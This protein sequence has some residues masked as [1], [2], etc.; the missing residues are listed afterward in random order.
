MTKLQQKSDELEARY[1]ETQQSAQ[2]RVNLQ[3][4]NNQMQHLD[5]HNA[6]DLNFSQFTLSY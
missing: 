5:K 4:A 2:V 6:T 1:K 3:M